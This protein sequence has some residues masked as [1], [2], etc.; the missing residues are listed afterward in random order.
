MHL[1]VKKDLGWQKDFCLFNYKLVW[2]S[3]GCTHKGVGIWVNLINE[4]LRKTKIRSDLVL[5]KKTFQ[6]SKRRIS[7]LSK[8]GSRWA[9]LNIAG[10]INEVS[11]NDQIWEELDLVVTIP[12]IDD[13]CSQGVGSWNFK[14]NLGIVSHNFLMRGRAA[15]VYGNTGPRATGHQVTALVSISL[16]F[17]QSFAQI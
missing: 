17:L 9:T 11:L 8:G 1:E 13:F 15:G 7:S 2:S 5:V 4:R 16:N 10:K 3:C 6:G 12:P 14:G